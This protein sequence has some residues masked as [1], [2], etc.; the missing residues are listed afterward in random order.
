MKQS[1][2]EPLIGRP[3][4]ESTEALYLQVAHAV[5]EALRAGRLRIG[6]R[7]PAEREL[8]LDIGVS[9]T[10]VTGA[11]QELQARG[12]LRGHV[13][14]GTMV[15]GMPPDAR[16]A[17]LPWAQRITPTAIEGMQIAY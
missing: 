7:L 13:G 12:I 5:E 16:H 4:A 17:A 10:T 9:R 11:Y 14:R 3:D 1:G 6:D 15:V 8:A 2:N